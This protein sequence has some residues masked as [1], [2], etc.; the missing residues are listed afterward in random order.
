MDNIELNSYFK[1]PYKLNHSKQSTII[2]Y[3]TPPTP[4]MQFFSSSILSISSLLLSYCS[5]HFQIE[6]PSIISI[7]ICLM[8]KLMSNH[9]KKVWI[10]HGV[11]RTFK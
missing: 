2:Y 9:A 8:D 6:I 11:K 3:K 1:I 5:T 10:E 7:T 4:F